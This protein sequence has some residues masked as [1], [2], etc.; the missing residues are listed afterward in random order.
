MSKKFLKS[1]T[2]P[3]TASYF[4]ITLSDGIY[5]LVPNLTVFK[6][7]SGYDYTSKLWIRFGM[8]NTSKKPIVTLDEEIN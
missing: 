2:P 6:Q 8:K 5:T 1:V 3:N 7:Y 4:N